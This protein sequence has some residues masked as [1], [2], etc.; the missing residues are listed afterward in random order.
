MRRCCLAGIFYRTGL[1]DNID[2]DFTRIFHFGLNPL[3]NIA[4]KLESCQIVDFAGSYE[5]AN[6]TAGLNGIGFLDAVEGIT[7]AFE[8]FKALEVDFDR[9]ASCTGRAP[10]IASA[11]CTMRLSREL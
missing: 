4:G 10:E 7:D 8:V 1:A 2:L 3:S 9:I 5:D 11:A 6:L